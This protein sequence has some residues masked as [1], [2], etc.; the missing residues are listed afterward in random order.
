[1]GSLI[2]EFTRKITEARKEV[3]FWRVKMSS[4]IYSVNNT[5]QVYREG[6]PRPPAHRSA[7][8]ETD[9]RFFCRSILWDTCISQQANTRLLAQPIPFNSGDGYV[10][11]CLLHRGISS[12]VSEPLPKLADFADPT[13]LN[14]KHSHQA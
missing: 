1:M 6:K 4:F 2:R 5:L 3:L 11:F 7:G 12:S 10:N 9:E 8:L 13:L 14:P